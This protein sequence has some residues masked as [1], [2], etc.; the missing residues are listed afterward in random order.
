MDNIRLNKI[1]R[2]LQKEMGDIIQRESFSIAGNAIITVTAVNVS[3]DLSVAR[4]YLSLFSA[5]NKPEE[6]LTLINEHKS[7]LRFELGKKVRNQMRKVP[8]LVFKID[9]SLDKIER[10]EKLL[11]GE[12]L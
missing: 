1:S 2:F 10:I 3:P 4:I 9:D 12:Q 8:E 7:K 5:Q 6:I 11:K